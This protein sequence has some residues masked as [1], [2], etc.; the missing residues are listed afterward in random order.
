M[1]SSEDLIIASE[2]INEAEELL[3]RYRCPESRNLA[4]KAFDI[5]SDEGD[6][7]DLNEIF[8]GHLDEGLYGYNGPSVC[9]YDWIARRIII[10][11]QNKIDKL[12]GM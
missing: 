11:T 10:A 9:H 4:S 1:V 7:A 5:V 2:L 8:G 6:R 3:D 12:R